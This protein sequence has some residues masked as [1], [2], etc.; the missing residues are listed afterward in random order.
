[1][2]GIYTLFEYRTNSDIIN[3]GLNASNNCKGDGDELYFY[4]FSTLGVCTRWNV[5][6]PRAG[7]DVKYNNTSQYEYL[8]K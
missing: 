2:G 1:M 5:T 6:E 4:Y 3:M 7:C 8:S